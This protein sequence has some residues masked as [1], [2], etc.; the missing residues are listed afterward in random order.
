MQA[1]SS[2]EMVKKSSNVKINPMSPIDLSSKSSQSDAWTSWY[3]QFKI[4]VK[5]S[6]LQ[7]EPYR[8]VRLHQIPNSGK[9]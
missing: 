5:A 4:F 6:G 7:D 9:H 1:E 2:Q 8:W 3:M